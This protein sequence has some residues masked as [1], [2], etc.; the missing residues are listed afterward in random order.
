MMPDASTDVK[1]QKREARKASVAEQVKS[2]VHTYL[3]EGWHTFFFNGSAKRQKKSGYVGGYGCCF[4]NAIRKVDMW[5]GTAVASQ[6]TGIRCPPPPWRK[7]NNK[8]ITGPN[9]RLLLHLS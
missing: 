9:P 6:V 5:G 3:R 8:P 7:M 2:L 4:L 1:K